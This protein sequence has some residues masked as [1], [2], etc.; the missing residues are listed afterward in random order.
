[1]KPEFPVVNLKPFAAGGNGDLY[2][3]QRRANGA[4]VVVKFL[5]EFRDGYARKAFSQ[6]V[7][8]LRRNVRGVVQLLYCAYRKPRLAHY[9]SRRAHVTCYTASL[10][11]VDF[12]CAS[13]FG[14]AQ[15]TNALAVTIKLLVK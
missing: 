3:G 9:G 5:R 6:Q 13:S 7:W 8:I 15:L 2:L 12:K 11:L 4:T 14:D 10:H 1:M